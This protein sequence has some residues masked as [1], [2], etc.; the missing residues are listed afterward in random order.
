MK[1]AVFKVFQFLTFVATLVT[2][3]YFI[4]GKFNKTKFIPK[5][6][7]IKDR[8]AEIYSEKSGGSELVGL[9]EFGEFITVIEKGEKWSKVA[10]WGFPISFILT[11]AIKLAPEKDE[12]S[13]EL[14]DSSKWIPQSQIYLEKNYY[15]GETNNGLPEGYGTKV[16]EGLHNSKYDPK[17]LQYIGYFKNGKYH[18]RGVLQ[19]SSEDY[20]GDF[21]KGFKHGRGIY[22]AKGIKEALNV[23]ALY[24]GEFNKGNY[25]GKGML[26]EEVIIGRFY[27][28]GNFQLGK[29]HGVGVE[30][31]EINDKTF[32]YQGEFRNGKYHY[33][34]LISV[35]CEVAY[36]GK[37]DKGLRVTKENNIIMNNCNDFIKREKMIFENKFFEL[38]QTHNNVIKYFR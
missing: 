3:G 30:I 8:I 4:N 21:F 6:F 19:T 34:K 25:H 27:Y 29:K 9:R 7:I 16:I 13:W 20:F 28:M 15:K 38:F 22:I 17:N 36:E 31:T 23:E 12:N 18:G 24:I 10:G 32:I 35:D 11:D 14:L 5:D 33:G 26:K 2:F 37:F 1:N